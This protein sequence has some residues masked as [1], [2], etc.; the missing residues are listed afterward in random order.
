MREDNHYRLVSL[1]DIIVSLFLILISLPLTSIVRYP[2]QEGQYVQY[3]MQ[4]GSE[5]CRDDRT[6]VG[7][8]LT[9]LSY[10]I[11]CPTILPPQNPFGATQGDRN[12]DHMFDVNPHIERIARTT[13]MTILHELFH[14]VYKLNSK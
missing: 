3:W 6:L 2:T 13:S 8:T 11:L 9:D 4:Y 10:I 7:Y 1:I 12:R 14:A 5:I